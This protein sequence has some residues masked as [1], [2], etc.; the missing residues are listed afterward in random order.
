MS[1]KWELVSGTGPM[2]RILTYSW[3]FKDDEKRAMIQVRLTTSGIKKESEYPFGGPCETCTLR[4]GCKDTG[5]PGTEQLWNSKVE[6]L[7]ELTWEEFQGKG[8]KV[9]GCSDWDD[10]TEE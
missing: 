8:I 7:T 6:R 2:P 5:Q 1:K 10:G 9:T 3:N 4:I